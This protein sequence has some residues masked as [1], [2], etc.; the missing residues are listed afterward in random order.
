METF[1]KRTLSQPYS[2]GDIQN[3]A[4]GTG[5]QEGGFPVLDAPPWSLSK[6]LS[7]LD[8]IPEVEGGPR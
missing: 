2:P 1:A 4:K 6:A 3:F 8:T 5:I 7:V